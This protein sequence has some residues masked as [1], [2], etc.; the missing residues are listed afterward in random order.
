MH[1][2]PVMGSFKKLFIPLGCGS[3]II[4]T[5]MLWETEAMVVHYFEFDSLEMTIEESRNMIKASFTLW[6]YC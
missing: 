1:Y 3:K 5:G 2:M 4:D 6:V